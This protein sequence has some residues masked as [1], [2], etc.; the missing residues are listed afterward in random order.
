MNVTELK[1]IFRYNGIG[2]EDPDPRLGPDEIRKHYGS[3]LYPELINAKISGPTKEG[4]VEVWS[5]T[6]QFGDK[7]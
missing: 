6:A 5:F 2:L 1:R 7:G 3:T 4:D